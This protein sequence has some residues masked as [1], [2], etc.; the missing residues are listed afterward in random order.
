MATY[1]IELRKLLDLN[2]KLD[3]YSYPIFDEN[4]R[5]SLNNKII[6]HFY[7]REIG[8][9]TPDRFN[10]M[11]RRK[12]IE[13]MPYYNQMY[14][15][16]LL[17]FNPLFTN[18]SVQTTIQDKTNKSNSKNKSKSTDN[19]QIGE[20]FTAN[21]DNTSS[22]NKTSN[23]ITDTTNDAT[24]YGNDTI[25][26]TSS[27]NDQLNEVFKDNIT[28]N[29]LV[30]NNLNSKT[31]SDETTH[32][33]N[34]TKATKST[35]F[36]DLPQTGLVWGSG[37]QEG[38]AVG[39]YAT[40]TTNETTNQTNSTDTNSNANTNVSNTGT[41]NTDGSSEQNST[42][43]NINDYN[44]I[45]KTIKNWSE[46]GK[47]VGNSKMSL[48]DKINQISNQKED[49]QRNTDRTNN[50]FNSSFNNSYQNE[51]FE[52]VVNNSG[53]Q[54]FSPSALLKEFRETFLNIDMMII[55]DLESIFMGVF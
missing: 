29:T 19:E 36:S 47:D 41:V 17:K 39:S 43:S 37:T 21:T 15:S 18:Y 12:M 54:G 14:M 8:A 9:E 11:L 44:T 32:G 55:E 42:K 49:T 33:D 13:I 30:T 48:D 23:Q 20:V 4:Y 40:T 51:Y 27:K 31:V 16:E 7:D 3:L 25:D 10:Y 38:E 28:N 24:K 34:V 22:E 45:D 26:Y 35:V 1:T 52:N 2:Y 5:E 46:N 6:L 50:Q 53:R